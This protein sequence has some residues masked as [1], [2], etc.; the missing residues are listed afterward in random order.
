MYTDA[1]RCQLSEPAKMQCDIRDQ[2]EAVLV[3]KVGEIRTPPRKK[4]PGEVWQKQG[5]VSPSEV[6]ELNKIL[7]TNGLD[8]DKLREIDKY[9]PGF[10][11]SVLDLAADSVVG[12]LPSRSNIMQRA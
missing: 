4:V 3:A 11:K 9:H 8:M 1:N 12:V 7:D 2:M 5:N 6:R 10:M